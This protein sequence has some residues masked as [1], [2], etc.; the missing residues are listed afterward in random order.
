MAQIDQ[1]LGGKAST[2]G[3]YS[4]VTST[5]YVGQSPGGDQLL[6]VLDDVKSSGAVFQPAVMPTL[7]MSEFD[8]AVASQIVSVLEQFTSQGIEVWLRF[9]HEM[10]WYSTEKASPHYDTTAPQF[11][12]AWKL[13]HAAA[14]SNSLIK[15]YWSPNVD[16]PSEPVAPWWPGAEYVDIVGIDCY[17]DSSSDLSSSAFSNC[18]S[19]FYKTYSLGYNLPFAI[20]ETAYSGPSGNDAWLAQLVG[21]DMCDWEN[22]IAASWFEYNQG[23]TDYLVVMGSSSLLAETKELLVENKGTNCTT[24]GSGGSGPTGTPF[25]ADTCTWG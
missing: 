4:Q 7:D 22:Y 16:S 2:Y 9:G 6:Q 17:P 19:S 24:S 21:Q 5:S 20:G 23:K 11:I 8:S 1:N 13:L 25:P 10:N 3:W 14:A 15:M 18:Y 12:A